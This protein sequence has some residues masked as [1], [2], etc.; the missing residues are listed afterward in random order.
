MS[1]GEKILDYKEDILKDLATLIEIESVSSVGSE[2]PQKALD[3]V[4]SRATEMGLNTKNILDIAGHAEY[5]SGDK[6]CGVLSHLDVVPAGDGWDYEPFK[7]TEKDG[8]LFGRGVVD[9]KGSAIVALYCLKA[10]K[11][12]NVTGKNAL[13][14]IFGTTEEVGMEDMRLYFANEPLPY[15]GF[16]PD[17]D[18]G[19]CKCEKGILQIEILA[20]NNNATTLT[21]FKSGNAVNAVPDSAYALLDCSEYDDHQLSRLADAKKGD[22]TFKYTIDGMMIISKGRASHACTP[23]KG[24][25]SAT[26]LID[27]LTS[28]FA[29]SVLGNLISFI[30][31]RISTEVNG[32]SL[33]LKMRDSASGPLTL[34]V[35]TINIDENHARATLDIRYP[36]TMDGSVILGRIRNLAQLEGLNVKILSHSKPL[37]LPENS[38]LL[39]LLNSSYKSVMGEDAP[40]YSTGGGTYA[41]TLQNRGVAFGPTFDDDITNIHDANESIDKEN[42]FK[43]AQICLEAMHQMLNV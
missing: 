1:F 35:G 36:V 40:T 3:F 14:V 15:L 25:N 31:S 21:E 39:P 7:L 30:D 29:H 43:H 6:Y 41:R 38:P 28:N 4:L 16:T 42:F 17:A 11:D 24:F 37:V 18:Y 32:N 8:R 26:H 23:E 9:D 22:F 13:R 12:N 20:E 2:A 27:L 10:L 33:G 34:N 5:G 19:I